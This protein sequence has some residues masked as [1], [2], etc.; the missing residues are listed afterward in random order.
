MAYLHMATGIFEFSG[1]TIALLLAVRR[2]RGGQ[3]PAARVYR[4]LARAAVVGYP[5]LGLAYLLNRLGGVMEAVHNAPRN[6]FPRTRPGC[7]ARQELSTFRPVSVKLSRAA[8]PL[9]DRPWRPDSA[10]QPRFGAPPDPR[11]AGT[12][13]VRAI[14]PAV[15]AL[16][17]GGGPRRSA[18]LRSWPRAG[19]WPPYVQ[20]P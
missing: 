20:G 9:A 12:F 2:T 4:N 17:A 11:R 16:R 1:I 18:A 6:T 10:P 3:A 15:A 14:W 7:R 8:G 19:R 5:L 13:L